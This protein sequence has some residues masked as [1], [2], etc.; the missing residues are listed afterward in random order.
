MIRSAFL[1]ALFFCSLCNAQNVTIRGKAHSW[2][3]GREISLSR[4]ADFVTMNRI[5]ETRDTIAADG[6]FELQLHAAHTAPVFFK[7]DNITAEM[8]VEPDYV[9]VIT[10]PEPDE[11]R[12]INRDVELPVNIGIV[13]ADSTELNALIFDFQRL[14][15]DIFIPKDGR[16]LG[17]PLLFRLTDSLQAA[18]QSRYGKISNDYFVAYVN[19]FIGSLN[20]S[21][22]R[23]EKFL[24]HHYIAGKE[25]RYHHYEY[26]KFFSSCFRGYIE[27]ISAR[28]PGQSV[29]NIINSK[30]D[31]KALAAFMKRDP[32]MVSDTLRELVTLVNLWDFYYSAE[33]IPDAVQQVVSQLLTDTRI[34]EHKT[35]ARTMLAYMG[36]LKPGSAAPDFSA[37]SRDGKMGSLA[38]F[39]GKWIYLNFFSSSNNSSLKE[40]AKI[41]DLQRR[42]GHKVVFLSVCLDDSVQQYKKFLRDN[43]RYGWNIWFSNDRSVSRSAKELY[44]IVGT[45]AYFLISNLGD[46]VE[47]PALAPSKGIEYKFN[48]IFKI[49]QRTNRSG[50]K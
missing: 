24:V 25:V 13:G 22:S 5:P 12:M 2:Y 48:A 45:E 39:R 16:H 32:L 14:Y 44:N 34:E 36:K 1:Y 26:M 29:F 17:R 9:Y 46:I 31:Y 33:F 3:A 4:A 11:S 20:A 23:G 7:V 6:S 40:M 19:Y 50:L 35:I 10:L 37:R 18:A 21:L 47:N 30:G 41:T 43:P 15:N 42:Y 8:Y 49:R 27:A 38:M 28:Y